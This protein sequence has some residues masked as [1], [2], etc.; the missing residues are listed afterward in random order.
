[1]GQGQYNGNQTSSQWEHLLTDDGVVHQMH[2]PFTVPARSIIIMHNLRPTPQPAICHRTKTTIC[3]QLTRYL[4]RSFKRPS[5]DLNLIFY[6]FRGSIP[7]LWAGESRKPHQQ[8]NLLYLLFSSSNGWYRALQS[9]ESWSH[10]NQQL[11]TALCSCMV[12]ARKTEIYEH[13]E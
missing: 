8:H 1:M 11:S 9:M 3:A 7:S 2:I 5:F 6:Q 4:W 13:E 10:R 12:V